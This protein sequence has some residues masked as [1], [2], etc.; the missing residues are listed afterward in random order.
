ME[1]LIK[2]PLQRL[3]QAIAQAQTEADLRQQFMADVG[4]YF[5]AKR[6][7]LY[8]LDQLPTIDDGTPSMLKKRFHWI[9]IR[10]YAI[11]FNIM[12]RFMMR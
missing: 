9:I 11:W 1:T 12:L 10:S 3:F 5:A 4:Q 8:F 7:S 2:A 6:W